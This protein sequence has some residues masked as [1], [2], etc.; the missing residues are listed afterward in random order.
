M[1][2][3]RRTRNVPGSMRSGVLPE[4]IRSLREIDRIRKRGDPG[5]DAT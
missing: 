4:G 3:L 5:C 2:S 1:D